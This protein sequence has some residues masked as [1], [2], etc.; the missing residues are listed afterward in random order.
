MQE[1]DKIRKIALEKMLLKSD[2]KIEM[3]VNMLSVDNV[4]FNIDMDT[5]I[6]ILNTLEVDEPL[7]QYEKLIDI[8]EYKDERV[9]V[10]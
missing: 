10:I 3:V 9:E 5:A 1:L 7:V 8:K 6:D 4:F 2:D